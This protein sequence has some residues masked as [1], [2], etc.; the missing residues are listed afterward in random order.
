[1]KI[2]K[3]EEMIKIQEARILQNTIEWSLRDLFAILGEDAERE[4]LQ[5]SPARFIKAMREMTD[6]YGADIEL[7]LEKTFDVGDSDEMI[8]VRNI[9]FVSLCEHHLLPFTGVAIV[10]YLPVSRVVGLSK[11]AR[12]V[13]AFA[14]RLQVQER[15]TTQ[16]T[17]A[18]DQCLETNGSAA[19]IKAKHS[20]MG[21]RGVRKPT[22]EMVTSSL[23]KGF[24]VPE[25]RA[26]FL[27]L[28]G[29]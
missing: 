25:V 3:D 23:T 13:D 15:L 6:G 2:V 19:L 18:L 1:M 4:G 12:L 27:A 29:I 28:A 24:R 14:H 9:E 8:V 16:I 11:I 22:A 20:C 21:C 5:E 17:S 7:I 10:A 26:E